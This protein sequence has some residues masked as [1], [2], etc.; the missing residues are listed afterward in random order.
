MMPCIS[1]K[2]HA[3]AKAFHSFSYYLVLIV[4]LNNLQCS[5]SALST[6]TPSLLNTN[7]S[8]H[9]SACSNVRDILTQ[10]G[11]ADKDIPTKLPMKGESP[12]GME[13]AFKCEHVMRSVVEILLGLLVK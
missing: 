10:R 12:K 4:L 7:H 2:L 11:V 6:T 1:S 9:E 5:T 8:S 13:T 3:D